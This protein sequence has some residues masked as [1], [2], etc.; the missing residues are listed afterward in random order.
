MSSTRRDFLVGLGAAAAA[1]SVPGRAAHALAGDSLLYPP[2]D[3]SYFDPPFI[4]GR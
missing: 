4:T 3:L 1:V 2:T